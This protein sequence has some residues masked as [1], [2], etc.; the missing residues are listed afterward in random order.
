MPGKFVDSL[1]QSKTR[2][3]ARVLAA[4]GIHHIGTQTAQIIASAS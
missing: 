2:G 1:V 3:L 4:L